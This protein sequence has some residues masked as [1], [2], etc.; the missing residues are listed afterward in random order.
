MDLIF[1]RKEAETQG[2]ESLLSAS[3]SS[4]FGFMLTF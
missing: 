1:Q 4:N 3:E 2:E